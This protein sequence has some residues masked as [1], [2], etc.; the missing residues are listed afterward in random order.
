M[1][2]SIYNA[3]LPQPNVPFLNPDGTVSRP[4]WYFL[5]ALN[6]RTGGN[7]PTPVIPATLQ[8]QINS[9]FVEQA[10]T[11]EGGENPSVGL[12]MATILETDPP[13]ANM[14]PALLAAWTAGDDGAAIVNPFLA[15]LLV[16][17]VA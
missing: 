6:A 5:I 1:S 2:A 8:A 7:T 13:P 15:A 17:D 12:S 14:V 16:S 10:M 3:T 9:L 4:W 11:D